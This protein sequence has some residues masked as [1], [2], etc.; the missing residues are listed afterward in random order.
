M[1]EYFWTG[2]L[3][4]ATLGYSQT[5][6]LLPPSDSLA[7]L[8]ANPTTDSS[9]QTTI[10]KKNVK[11]IPIKK[12]KK[13]PLSWLP[14]DTSWAVPNLGP[15][16]LS[17][18]F[19]YKSS[20]SFVKLPPSLTDATKSYYLRI[21]A[22]RALE[23]MIQDAGK[24]GIRLRVVS[25]TRSFA[26]QKNIWENKWLGRGPG[27]VRYDTIINPLQKALAITSFSSMPG[28]S[29]H[30]WGTDVDLNSVEP[31]FFE[32]GKG[33]KAYAWLRAHASKYG[34]C[35]VYK[36]KGKAKGRSGYND[37]AWHWS[38]I[39]LARPL[40]DQYS[41]KVPTS[42]IVQG[43]SGAEALNGPVVLSQYIWGIAPE[44]K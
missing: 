43:F 13:A 37:E 10:E 32:K 35:Q 12:V 22:A 16:E 23:R 2:L 36:G 25:A 24:D 1:Q 7:T 9:I 15:K 34:Y 42:M 26:E 17:G 29:R 40:I 11:N 38:Y 14:T 18:R 20:K 31:S 39:P 6:S 4:L 28:T 19:D 41:R 3:A 44:C 8:S 5:D 27:G 33:A 21:P 30:H